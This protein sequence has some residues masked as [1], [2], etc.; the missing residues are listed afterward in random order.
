[1]QYIR[2][3]FDLVWL[4]SFLTDPC[5]CSW[6]QLG[7]QYIRRHRTL[8]ALG[9]FVHATPINITRRFNATLN[10]VF[11]VLKYKNMTLMALIVQYNT[12]HDFNGHYCPRMCSW[13]DSHTLSF[14]THR[15]LVA[16]IG[17]VI[18]YLNFH[19]SPHINYPK[20]NNAFTIC[21]YCKG[22]ANRLLNPYPQKLLHPSTPCFLD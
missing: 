17:V 2:Y 10:H 15:C 6:N 12:L 20:C 16:L 19:G 18:S 9:N 3:T 8:V 1:M 11:S 21:C 14:K 13:P 7:G 5:P 4:T 22:K